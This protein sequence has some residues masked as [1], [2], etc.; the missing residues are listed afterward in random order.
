MEQSGVKRTVLKEIPKTEDVIVRI[1][2]AAVAGVEWL[3]IRDYV[4]SSGSYQRGVTL[5]WTRP[6]NAPAEARS[7][8]VPDPK[9]SNPVN[10]RRCGRLMGYTAQKASV[11]ARCADVECAS[12]QPASLHE[13]R[14]AVVELLAAIGLS[15]SE[16]AGCVGL[17]QQMI[18]KM[19]A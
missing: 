4:V 5:P 10:C 2:H 8:P 11:K 16:I 17:T 12:T 19:L 7:V 18:G 13:D 1:S 3:D 15:Q 9:Y 14:D 6:E